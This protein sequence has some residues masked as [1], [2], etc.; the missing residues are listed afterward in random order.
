MTKTRSPLVTKLLTTLKRRLRAVCRAEF[1]S[2][3]IMVVGDGLYA[4]RR[5]QT[6]HS[7]CV[8]FRDDGVYCSRTLPRDPTQIYSYAEYDHKVAADWVRNHL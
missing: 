3:Q 4:Q 6:M 8:E 7:V 2:I 1:G 5:V